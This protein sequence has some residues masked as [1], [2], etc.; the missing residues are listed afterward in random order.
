MGFV[1]ILDGGSG[2]WYGWF[3]GLLVEYGGLWLFAW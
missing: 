1:G 2:F 3:L